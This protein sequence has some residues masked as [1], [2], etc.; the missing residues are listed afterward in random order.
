[1]SLECQK[2]EENFCC[3]YLGQR[4]C[5]E[6]CRRLDCF[7]ISCQLFNIEEKSPAIHCQNCSVLSECDRYQYLGRVNGRH[8]YSLHIH[9]IDHCQIE[10]CPHKD[11]STVELSRLIPPSHYSHLVQDGSS[12]Q[13]INVHQPGAGS[14]QLEGRKTPIP[15]GKAYSRMVPRITKKNRGRPKGLLATK[16]ARRTG[17]GPRRSRGKSNV[18]ERYRLSSEAVIKTRKVNRP[19]YRGM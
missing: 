8:S 9:C 10:A 2:C 5:N 1:L 14:Q 3:I 15:S 18:G 4:T 16:R 13:A 11:E 7:C 17:R 12:S 6:H 19:C